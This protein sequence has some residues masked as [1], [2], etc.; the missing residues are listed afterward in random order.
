MTFRSQNKALHI[1]PYTYGAVENAK[2]I[3]VLLY[4]YSYDTSL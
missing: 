2:D 1:I 4:D 3:D